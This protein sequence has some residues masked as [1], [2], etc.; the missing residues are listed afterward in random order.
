METSILL[1]K[2]AIEIIAITNN[3]QMWDK[4]WS[5]SCSL[6]I[7][8]CKNCTYNKKKHII[9]NTKYYRKLLLD[10]NLSNNLIA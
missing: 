4:K 3:T 6:Y 9:V 8:K 2:S 7:Y 10:T 1:H 5:I